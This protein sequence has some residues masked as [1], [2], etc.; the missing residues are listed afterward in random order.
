MSVIATV[1]LPSDEFPLG[2]VFSSDE[3]GRMTV[4]TTVPTSE[5]IIP[6]VW[7]PDTVSERTLEKLEN[8]SAISAA[9]VIDEA[10]GYRL[11]KLEWENEV[12]GVLDAIQGTDA[13][14][15]S[16]FGTADRWTFRLRFPDYETLSTFHRKCLEK[17]VSI[18]LVQVYEASESRGN[19]LY[20]LTDPQRDLLVTAYEEGYFEVPRGTSLVELGEQLEISDSAV[21]QRLRRGLKSLLETTVVDGTGG[22]VDGDSPDT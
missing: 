4:E 3:T 8:R 5:E 17:D 11:V 1:E 6:Y 19:G 13:I 20:G 15:T 14:V 10:D 7:I 2:R 18:E 21:S 12:D 9:S 22:A 16:S